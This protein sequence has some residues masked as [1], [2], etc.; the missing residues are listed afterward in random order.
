M[1]V[2]KYTRFAHENAPKNQTLEHYIHDLKE[3]KAVKKNE[4]A[5][6]NAIYDLRLMA[7]TYDVTNKD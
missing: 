5:I 3:Q 4:E 7:E 1:G 6:Q 2:L